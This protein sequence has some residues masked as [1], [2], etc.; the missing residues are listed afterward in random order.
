MLHDVPM[1]QG[2]LLVQL[3]ALQLEPVRVT[4]PW[5]LHLLGVSIVHEFWMQHG[6]GE[7]WVH[8]VVEQVAPVLGVPFFR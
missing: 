4:P 7:G 2:S 8:V 5:F 6:S 3:T 1:Q